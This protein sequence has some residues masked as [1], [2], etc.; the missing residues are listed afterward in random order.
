[1]GADGSRSPAARVMDEAIDL[2]IEGRS[3]YPARAAFI[4]AD[5]PSVGHHIRRAAD[6]GLSV[7]LVSGDGN[8]RVLKP[9]LGGPKDPRS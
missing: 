4:D 6:D 1:M 9:E 5:V 8:I 3:P 2:A 7:V